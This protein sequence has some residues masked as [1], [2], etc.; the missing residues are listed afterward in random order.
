M[1]GLEPQSLVEVEGPHHHEYQ[2]HDEAKD[3]HDDDFP[4]A[5]EEEEAH[6]MDSYTG[7]SS[8]VPVLPQYAH[9][10]ARCMHVKGRCI[11]VIFV[12]CFGE[13]CG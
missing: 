1:H 2:E 6:K 13:D 4:Y 3:A 9:H 8:D 7:G 10:V 5:N 11:D 12:L